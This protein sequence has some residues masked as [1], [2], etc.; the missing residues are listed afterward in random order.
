MGMAKQ[1]DQTSGYGPSET[2]ADYY[3]DTVTY[4]WFVFGIEMECSEWFF[5]LVDSHIAETLSC[6]TSYPLIVFVFGYW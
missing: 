3:L 4:I 5:P 1:R 6:A 2:H